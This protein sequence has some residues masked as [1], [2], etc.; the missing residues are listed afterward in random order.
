MRGAVCAVR[1]VRPLRSAG[2]ATT[3]DDMDV[4]WRSARMADIF[5]SGFGGRLSVALKKKTLYA[6]AKF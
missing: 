6:P 5:N 1:S 3:R 2:R 4:S